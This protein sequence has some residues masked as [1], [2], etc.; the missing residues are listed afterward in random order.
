[1]DGKD[2][3]DMGFKQG[4]VFRVI[5]TE[6]EDQQLEGLVSSREEALQY[7]KEHFTA[8]SSNG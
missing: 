3:L 1:M 4:P 8:L 6:V 7:V 5:L 2:L